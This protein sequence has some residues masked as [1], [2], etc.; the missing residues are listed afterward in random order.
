MNSTL[1]NAK[2]C[3][4]WE[5][6]VSA[7]LFWEGCFSGGR[8]TTF[9]VQSCVGKVIAETSEKCSVHIGRYMYFAGDNFEFKSASTL[10][11][12]PC[13][14]FFYIYFVLQK[15]GVHFCF[16]V[17]WYHSTCILLEKGKILPQ[18]NK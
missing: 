9:C 10:L 13:N 7:V 3:C 5:L 2:P 17:P 14:Q 11:P 15:K 16:V 6:F 4:Q 1:Q 12:V 18:L 8:D